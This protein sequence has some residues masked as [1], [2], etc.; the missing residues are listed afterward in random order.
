MNEEEIDCDARQQ[1]VKDD[2][3]VPDNRKREKQIE[4]VRGIEY[5]GLQCGE[6][7]YAAILVGIPEWKN[8]V[9]EKVYPQDLGRDKKGG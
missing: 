1:K 4:D 3:P 7:R 5:A 8:S 6:E 9:L 2:Q